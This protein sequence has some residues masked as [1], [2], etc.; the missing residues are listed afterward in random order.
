MY[1]LI[2]GVLGERENHTASLEIITYCHL[3]EYNILWL[4]RDIWPDSL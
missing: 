4:G 3:Y 1:L 2:S